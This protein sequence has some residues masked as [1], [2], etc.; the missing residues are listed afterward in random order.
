ME[1]ACERMRRERPRWWVTALARVALLLWAG[2]GVQCS[3]A[4]LPSRQSALSRRGKEALPGTQLLENAIRL[5]GGADFGVAD[6]VTPDELREIGSDVLKM[7]QVS[8]KETAE[9]EEEERKRK[10]RPQ[11]SVSKLSFEERLAQK[12]EAARQVGAEMMAEH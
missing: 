7:W 6:N 3:H 11:Q 2:Y 5:R 12:E 9:E 4:V 1:A 8:H 10:A